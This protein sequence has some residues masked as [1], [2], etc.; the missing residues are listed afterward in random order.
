[1]GSRGPVPK[2]S[3]A[4]AGHRTKAESPDKVKRDGV[5][6][7]PSP[8]D[9]WH[10]Q[11]RRWYESLASS[12][13]ADYYEPSDWMHAQY[14]AHLMSEVLKGNAGAEVAKAVLSGMQELGTTESSRRRMKIEVERQLPAAKRDDAKVTAMSSYRRQTASG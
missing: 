14:V 10:G 12:G 8:S 6:E 13:Q 9:D 1:M 11:A 7:Q 2:R 4:R 3:S 5:V